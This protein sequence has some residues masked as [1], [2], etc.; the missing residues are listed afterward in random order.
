M[1]AERSTMLG[2]RFKQDH[3]YLI[4]IKQGFIAFLYYNTSGARGSCIRP[5][6]KAKANTFQAIVWPRMDRP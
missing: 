4:H 5:C 6:K 1:K 2:E 3:F